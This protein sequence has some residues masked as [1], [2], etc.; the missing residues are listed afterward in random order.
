MGNYEAIAYA[1]VALFELQS[2]GKEVTPLKL[3]A[4]MLSLMDM[5]TESMIYKK[6]Q[7]KGLI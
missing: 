7:E 2:E 1:V 5:N 3:K 4:R 6:A